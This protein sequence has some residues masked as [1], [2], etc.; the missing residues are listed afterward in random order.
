MNLDWGGATTPDERQ[1]SISSKS[2]AS[3]EGLRFISAEHKPIPDNRIKI[4]DEYK[5][6]RVEQKKHKHTN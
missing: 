4:P 5:Q 1:V 2:N 3:V 6:I